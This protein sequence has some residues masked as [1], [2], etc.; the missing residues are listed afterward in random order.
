[1]PASSGVFLDVLPALQRVPTMAN[2]VGIE[3]AVG[4]EVERAY[5]GNVSISEAIQS[6]NELTGEFFDHGTTP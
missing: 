1:M 3:E 4:K 2:W 6:A 5:Y